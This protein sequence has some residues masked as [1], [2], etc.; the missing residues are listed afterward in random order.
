MFRIT[1][2]A[3]VSGALQLRLEGT[4]TGAE[5]SLLDGALREIDRRELTLDL[6]GVRWIDGPA[7]ARLQALRAEGAAFVACSPYLERLLATHE[8]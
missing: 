2:A 4:L 7:A 3:D 6:A 1:R 8:R 5:I